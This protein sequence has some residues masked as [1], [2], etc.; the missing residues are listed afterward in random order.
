VTEWVRN[1]RVAGECTL[2]VGRRR[3]QVRLI[4]I[5]DA[6]KPEIL[7]SYLRRWKWEMGQFFD[8]VGADATDEQLLAIAP[9]Y[10]VLRLEP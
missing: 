6:A 9:S 7:R 2:L 5:T 10:P 4:E 1:V 8:G 3:E